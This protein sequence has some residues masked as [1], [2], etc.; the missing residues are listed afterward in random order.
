MTISGSNGYGTI[1]ENLLPVTGAFTLSNAEYLGPVVVENGGVFNLY[2][3]TDPYAD[4]FQSLTVNSGG[5]ANIYGGT[6][7]SIYTETIATH[8]TNFG[9]ISLQNTPIQIFDGILNSPGA[10]LN[11]FGASSIAL[12]TS[13]GFLT[14]LGTIIQNSSPTV[15]NT[16][17]YF[18][19]PSQSVNFDNSRGIITNLSGTL[20]LESIT[21]DAVSGSYFT[22]TG[23]TTQFAGPTNR[24]LTL[25]NPLALLGSG[26]YQFV[27]GNLFLAGTIPS[28]LS[29]IGGLLQLAPGFQGGTITNLSLDG[30]TLTNSSTAPTL[31]TGVFSVTNSGL[32]NG[33]INGAAV[34]GNFIVTN[35]GVIIANS[36]IFNGALAQTNGGTINFY[37]SFTYSNVL[38]GPGC[39][40]N[41]SGWLDYGILSIGP[42]AT[43]NLINN[44]NSQFGYYVSGLVQYANLTNAGTINLTNSGISLNQEPPGT[45]TN[46]PSGGIINLPSGTI[47]FWGSTGI[48]GLPGYV[49][50]EGQIIS[51]ASGLSGF[52]ISSGTNSG[53]IESEDGTVVLGGDWTLLPSGTLSVVL[54]GPANYGTFTLT[55]NEMSPAPGGVVQLAGN[56]TATLGNGYIPF[57]G[58][59]FNVLSYGAETGNF[60]FVTPPSA[61][62][63]SESY[64][65][66]SFV[67]TEDGGLPA[68]SAAIHSGANIVFAGS[69]GKPGG[70]FEILTSTNLAL[71]LSEWT[72][73]STNTFSGG[74]T[75]S[76]TNAI[77]NQSLSRF[78]IFRDL[79]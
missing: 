66:M 70:T 46:V 4:Q 64:G 14:N 38:A 51:S 26:Q 76:E 6:N 56:F 17:S 8:W 44:F 42:G 53:T 61:G 50:N 19:N 23:A 77:G 63:W 36:S 49:L 24:S 68:F 45:L 78:F 16:I 31:V 27:S 40:I 71:P 74:G 57:S 72:V 48:S 79:Q 28:N 67:L 12:A 59:S 25:G 60:A 9:T 52:E 13:G 5:T 35:H 73:L 2:Q 62:Q 1:L 21:S 10:T 39:T 7:P 43:L 3:I 55:T 18:L 54:N 15:T 33:L 37:Q 30:I 11:L 75:F 20:L 47:H 34:Y 29:L 22:A 69:G 65:A 32:A 41:A 58:A